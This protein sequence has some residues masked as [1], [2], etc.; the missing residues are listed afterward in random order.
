MRFIATQKQKNV[1]GWSFVTDP[2][3]IP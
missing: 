3:T 1:S 2:T